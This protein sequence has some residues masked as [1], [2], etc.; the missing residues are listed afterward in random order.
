VTISDEKPDT[1]E[2]TEAYGDQLG[3]DITPDNAFVVIARELR[4]IRQNLDA[5]TYDPNC[6]TVVD[7]I[8]S[9]LHDN[10]RTFPAKPGPRGESVAELLARIAAALEDR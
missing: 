8:G 6:E 1:K 10:L 5:M 3:R 9:A 2:E 7:R 4:F